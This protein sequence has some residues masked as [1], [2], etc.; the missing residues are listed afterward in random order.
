MHKET[1]TSGFWILDRLLVRL[2]AADGESTTGQKVTSLKG[3]L[4]DEL[5]HDL[6]S[7]NKPRSGY[8]HDMLYSD[9]VKLAQKIDTC[10]SS[11]EKIACSQ[12]STQS[13][14][15][16]NSSLGINFVDFVAHPLP[17][18]RIDYVHIF[19]KN[20]DALTLKGCQLEIWDFMMGTLLI[21]YE[22]SIKG[23][24]DPGEHL[25]IALQGN[26]ESNGFHQADA[27]SWFTEKH[28]WVS[29]GDPASN[30]Y[31]KI[32]T[33][34]ILFFRFLD[35]NRIPRATMRIERRCE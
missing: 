29:T 27:V 16:S 26:T 5:F 31:K 34:P 22:F 20:D 30:T 21:K 9:V 25:L 3:K 14:F 17:N 11:L 19:N 2:G 12:Q 8:F 7:I 23:T 28:W 1:I 4:P 18:T 24:F 33:A 10:I 32:R 15:D 35:Q 6:L 13:N